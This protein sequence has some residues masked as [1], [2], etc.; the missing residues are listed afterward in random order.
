MAHRPET[1]HLSMFNPL[2]GST[3]PAVPGGS[4]IPQPK[5][6]SVMAPEELVARAQEGD[7]EAAAELAKREQKPPFTPPSQQQPGSPPVPPDQPGQSLMTKGADAL[8]RGMDWIGEQ[9]RNP[10]TGQQMGGRGT[11]AGRFVPEFDPTMQGPPPP[12]PQ[13][14]MGPEM[15]GPPP[16]PQP[17]MPTP[18]AAA[19]PGGM[20]PMPAEMPAPPMGPEMGGAPP[21]MPPMGPMTP[22]MPG[23]D[24]QPMDASQFPEEPGF[25][26]RFMEG[27]TGGDDSSRAQ[28]GRMLMSFGLNMMQASEA[29]PGS[30]VGPSLFGAMGAA[31]GA[32]MQDQISQRMFRDKLKAGSADKA[33]DRAV[34][35]RGQDIQAEHTAALRE[36]TKAWREQQ[37]E[38]ARARVGVQ[39]DDQHRRQREQY[40][41]INGLTAATMAGIPP[42]KQ[43]EWIEKKLQEVDRY[44]DSQRKKYGQPVRSS[45]TPVQSPVGG[46]QLGTYTKATYRKAQ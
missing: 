28:F 20:T 30:K 25:F 36:D 5:P 33:A 35:M 2:G 24:I 44:F 15:F 39:I 12:P 6:Y 1:K 41:G 21:F 22:M 37:D 11:P 3:Q 9:Y 31:G 27:L 43:S 7:A 18:P 32:T 16:M 38:V 17:P 19:A 23:Q 13:A 45:G 14:Q 8:G 42:D 4:P 29:R 26:D 34:K 10:Q 40:E 46:Q